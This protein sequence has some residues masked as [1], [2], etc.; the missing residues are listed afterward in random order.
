MRNEELKKLFGM[1]PSIVFFIPHS[2]FLIPYSSFLIP[3]SSFLIP[4]SSLKIRLPGQEQGFPGFG[5]AAFGQE[6]LG[7]LGELLL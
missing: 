4:H 1:T 7:Q 3:Y 5:Q 2:S 6:L